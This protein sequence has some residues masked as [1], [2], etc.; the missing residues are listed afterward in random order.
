VNS[1]PAY[2]TNGCVQKIDGAHVRS[3]VK[4]GPIDEHHR[5]PSVHCK[6]RSRYLQILLVSRQVLKIFCKQIMVRTH[7]RYHVP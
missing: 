6:V 4:V 2:W 1:A 3:D 7:Q 5:T